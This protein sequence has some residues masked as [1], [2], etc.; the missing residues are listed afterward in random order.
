MR[1]THSRQLSTYGYGA[2]G[3]G[4]SCGSCTTCSQAAYGNAA[5]PASWSAV[6]AVTRG[7]FLFL[8]LTLVGLAGSL[9]VG[10]G[11]GVVANAVL[12]RNK[13]SARADALVENSLTVAS[14][15]PALLGVGAGSY[16]V[17]R[18]YMDY[19]KAKGK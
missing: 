19:T 3:C 9:A 16:G 6:D 11:S 15:V 13:R 18:T 1:Y 10:L 2:Y 8:G 12:P 5:Y 14:V 17:Y 4:T 7:G